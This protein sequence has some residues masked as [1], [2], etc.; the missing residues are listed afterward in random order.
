MV[1]SSSDL[2]LNL[3]LFVVNKLKKQA[4]ASKLH[5]LLEKKNN[6]F[7]RNKANNRTDKIWRDLLDL[8]LW[9]TWRRQQQNADHQS[10]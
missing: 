5:K 9:K 6:K 7:Q 10:K 3:E 4:P 2:D 8:V 1:N